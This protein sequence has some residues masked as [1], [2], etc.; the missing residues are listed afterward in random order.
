MNTPISP[1]LN[2]HGGGQIWQG[3]YKGYMSLHIHPQ[4]LFRVRHYGTQFP[5][6]I[7]DLPLEDAVAEVPAVAMVSPICFGIV[8]TWTINS[9]VTLSVESIPHKFVLLI[10]LSHSA[11]LTGRGNVQ[12]AHSESMRYAKE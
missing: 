3:L 1:E 8:T 4:I 2:K 12:L 10:A 5:P 6:N 9:D 7:L 11:L